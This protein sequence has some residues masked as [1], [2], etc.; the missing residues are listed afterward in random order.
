MESGLPLDPRTGDYVRRA[1]RS[2]RR[3]EIGPA[4]ALRLFPPDWV[5][6]GMGPPGTYPV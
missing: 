6:F 1:G 2:Y 4:W 5:G 3:E